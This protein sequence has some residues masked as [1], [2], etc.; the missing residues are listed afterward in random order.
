MDQQDLRRLEN[1]CIQ[2]NPPECTAA[3]PLHVDGRAFAGAV[4]QGNWTEA[5][6]VL[7][8]TMPLPNILGRICDA[9]C[10]ARCKRKEAV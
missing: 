9:P 4:A 10:E 3:C 2:E 8:R 6:K 1:Q 7:R 5:L